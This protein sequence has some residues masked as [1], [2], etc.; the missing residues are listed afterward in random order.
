PSVSPEGLQL[1]RALI[2]LNPVDRFSA[3]RS[4][5][6]PFFTQHPQYDAIPYQPPMLEA[7]IGRRQ[8]EIVFT[9]ASKKALKPKSK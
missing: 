3:L 7:N 5:Q 8:P 6:L 4:L 2:Q 9:E 1:I